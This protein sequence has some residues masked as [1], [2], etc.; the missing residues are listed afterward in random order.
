MTSAIRLVATL[1]VAAGA[2]FAWSFVILYRRYDWRATDEGRHIMGFTLMVAI[3][4][5]LS[6][7]VRLFGP[8]PFAPFVAVGLYGWIVWLLFSRLRLLVRAQ[9]G[10]RDKP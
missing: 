3:T 4:L 2:V 7:E 9:R 8:F 6:L 1:L 5:T 10:S